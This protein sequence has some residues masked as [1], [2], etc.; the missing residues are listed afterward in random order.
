MKVE[1]AEFVSAQ[2][3]WPA[4]TRAS[5]VTATSENERIRLFHDGLWIATSHG[6]AAVA[7]LAGVRLTTEFVS[8]AVYGWFVLLN[9]VVALL[10]GVL[11]Q[12]TSQ[13]ALRFYPQFAKVDAVSALTQH[14]IAVFASRWLWSLGLFSAACLV[15]LAWFH[16]F[17]ATVW[18]LLAVAMGLDAWKTK[19]I[20]D[21]CA[22][23]EQARYAGFFLA[24]SIARPLG[25]VTAAWALEPTLEALLLGQCLGVCAV[26]CRASRP[27]SGTKVSHAHGGESAREEVNRA[28]EELAGFAAP[29]V[30]APVLSWISAMA[31]RYMLGAI[32]G[33]ADAGIY[34]AAYGLASRPMLMIGAVT[35]ATFRQSLY[36]SVSAR[37]KG[38]TRSILTG[39]IIV[40]GAGGAAAATL[41]GILGPLIAHYVLAEEYREMAVR[42]LPWIAAG[43]V[44]LLLSDIAGRVMH[45]NLF[46]RQTT[47]VQTI[48]AG[49]SIVAGI[50]GAVSWGALGVAIA[51]PVCY[52]F[53]LA[54][55]AVVLVLLLR[56]GEVLFGSE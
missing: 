32:L 23:R 30:W 42:L 45:A 26:L 21:R 9:G 36:D 24:D 10:Q 6:L 12:P 15:D 44:S 14:L 39:W 31:D 47:A 18:I 27:V 28:K 40:N 56:R 29:L 49:M 1:R 3:T 33:I 38:K 19:E 17:G 50:I 25:A 8:P 34:A 5:A 2:A 4:V 55:N 41:I 48:A 46:V 35:D 13:A 43:H 7:T 20:I 51:V 16:A 11:L 22:A 53:Q 37:D 52:S 54:A